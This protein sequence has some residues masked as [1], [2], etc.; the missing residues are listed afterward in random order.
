MVILEVMDIICLLLS[1]NYELYSI[2]KPGP[3]S[4]ELKGSANKEISQMLHSDSIVICSDTNDY[5]LN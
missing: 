1:K 5:E 2:D 3:S 4:S